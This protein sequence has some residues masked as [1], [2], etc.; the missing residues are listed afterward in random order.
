MA[1]TDHYTLIQCARSGRIF[2]SFSSCHRCTG[3]AEFNPLRIPGP[4][5]PDGIE[6]LALSLF[7]L[8]FDDI[9]V[10]R[11]KNSTLDYAKLREGK[12]IEQVCPLQEKAFWCYGSQSFFV[13][14]LILLGIHSVRN[15][16]KAWSYSKAQ[17]LHDIMPC[18]Q[19]ELI[20]AIL[21]VITRSEEDSW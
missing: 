7:K 12:K 15:Y 14:T 6:V 1:D 11:V 17:G 5:I 18:Q 21:Q 16:H 19:F 10:E 3:Q 2:L 8:F 20:G 9:A 4:H 13:G